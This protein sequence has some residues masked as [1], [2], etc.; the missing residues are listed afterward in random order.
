MSVVLWY[1]VEVA[2]AGSS[3]ATFG[4]GGIGGLIGAL[5]STPGDRLPV[6]ISND[7]LSGALT[8]DAEITV[9]MTEGA[10]ADTFDVTLYN[11]PLA[12]A[13]L[14]RS[15]LTATPVNATISLGYFDEPATRN[16]D[17]G[18]VLVGRIIKVGGAVAGDGLATTVITGQE[19]A[20]YLL[21]KAKA[22]ASPTQFTSAIE[23]ARQL[24]KDAHVPLAD[25]SS[26]P[27]DLTGVTVRGEST[28]DILG[29]LADRFEIPIVVRDGTLFLGASVGSE[30]EEGPV[31]FDP[32]TNIVALRNADAE[33]TEQTQDAPV[34]TTVTVTVL[35]DPRLRVGQFARISGLTGVPTTP[36]RISKV[37]HS[38]GPSR[39]YTAEV[40]LIAAGP[41]ERALVATG[42]QSTVSRM[43]EAIERARTNHPAIDVGEVTG[44]TAGSDAHVAT[45]NYAQTP[46][47]TVAAPSVQSPV[48]QSESLHDKPIAAVFAFDRTGLMVPV[49]PGMRALLAHNRG[50]VNDA[51]VAGFLWPT[52]D[53]ALRR[54]DN[55]QGDYWLALPTGLDPDQRPTGKGVNDLTDASGFR[56]IQAAGL[57]VLVGTDA[58]P[59]VGTRPDPPA[60]ASI[61]I[62][63]Q[64]GTVITIGPEGEVTITTNNKAITLTN[65]SVKLSLDG[66]SVAVA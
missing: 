59:E 26:L 28:L 33:D 3:G 40:A 16:T 7:I 50:L 31:A 64:S 48:D 58:L 45:M 35:G 30:G 34:R 9:T 6:T 11:L 39:G 51:V 18:R 57:H 44:Y 42:V 20:G 38:F 1:K 36:M 55:K 32:D 22:S 24:A 65:G 60:D 52:A 17:A 14:I 27:G 2:E 5:T 37:V 63:H 47:S 41:G 66:S 53:P 19:E 15:T 25:A 23:Y 46:R 62:E 21:R 56:V 10:A 54:P 4:L 13:D 49:Y 12:T 29:D 61:R 8:L 43:S